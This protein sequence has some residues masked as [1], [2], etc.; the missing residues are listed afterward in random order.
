MVGFVPV[1]ATADA[2]PH[3]TVHAVIP[4]PARKDC[5]PAPTT[6]WKAYVAPQAPSCTLTRYT[7]VCALHVHSPQSLIC[8][9]HIVILAKVLKFSYSLV[10]IDV[11]GR[12]KKPDTDKTE[13]NEETGKR[14]GS[15]EKQAEMRKH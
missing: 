15:Q 9:E 5:P 6:S 11:I 1:Y 13:R 7:F 12:K 4:V 3:S 10:Y 14:A 8:K 2:H